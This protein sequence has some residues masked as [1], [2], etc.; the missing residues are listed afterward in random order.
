MHE[1]PRKPGKYGRAFDWRLSHGPDRLQDEAAAGMSRLASSDFPDILEDFLS[2]SRKRQQNPTAL[3]RLQIHMLEELLIQES[4]VKHYRERIVELESPMASGNADERQKEIAFAKGQRFFYRMYANAM[5]AIGD[6]IAWRAFGYDRAAIRLLGERQTKQHVSSEGTVQELREW[7]Y[8]FDTGSGIAILNALTNCLAIADVTVVRHDGSIEIVEVKSSK[9]KSSRKIRQKQ[10]MKEVVTLIGTGAGQNEGK[11]VSIEILRITPESYLDKV[12]ELLQTAGEK[13]WAARR[14]SDWLYVEA[15]DFRKFT[16]EDEVKEPTGKMREAAMGEWKK[17]G[18]YI[19]DMN[20]LDAIGY[21]PN[22]APFSIFPFRARMCVDLLIGATC[23][24]SFLNV[25]A[26]EREFTRRGWTLEKD[27]RT[28]MKEKSQESM[29][30][31]RKGPFH[32]TVTP[33]DFMRMLVE[34]LRPKTLIDAIE[35]KYRQGPSADTGYLLAIFQ[36]E[37]KMWN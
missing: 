36:D 35:A 27:L 3:A 22:S 15:F 18:D 32:C 23:Y 33:A 14:I 7:S 24:V 30:E 28:L 11:D 26:V 6:G 5:R 8:H 10:A 9:T 13:G 4:V 21:S 31:V 25:N 37:Y 20:S 2:I 19:H 17:R 34:T 29:L 1:Q 12:E 16:S